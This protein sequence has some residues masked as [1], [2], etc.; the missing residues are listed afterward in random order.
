MNK[1]YS[2]IVWENY[3]SMDTP[4]NEANLNR[5]DDALNTIDDRVVEMS[6]T[7]LDKNTAYTMVK[8]ISFNEDTGIFTITYL[9]G[10]TTTLDTKL[11]KL[12][13][14]FGFNPEIEKLT[15]TL[16]DGTVQEVDLSA[17]ISKYEFADSD[18][19]AFTVDSSGKVTA[20][21]KEGSIQGKHLQPNYLADVTQQAEAAA[22]SA[23]SAENSASAASASAVAAAEAAK[24]AE[25]ASGVSIAST[26]K[27]GIVKP[28][29]ETITVGA[30]GTIAVSETVTKEISDVRNDLTN[31]THTASEVGAV[32]TSEFAKTFSSYTSNITGKGWYRVAKIPSNYGSNSCEFVITTDYANNYPM[33]CKLKY[34][35]AHTTHKIYALDVLMYNNSNVI[36]NARITTDGT[37]SYL[38][39]Y[40]ISSARNTVKIDVMD[41]DNITGKL[42]SA[43]EPVAT[44]ETVDGVTVH[45]YY[46]IPTNLKLAS[47]YEFIGSATGTTQIS[48]D[49]SQY[50]ELVYNVYVDGVGTFS[51]TFII[52]G[53]HING[54]ENMHVYVQYNPEENF[55]KVVEAKFNGTDVTSRATLHVY[56]RRK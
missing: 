55:A 23:E 50:S 44:S 53:W 12:A 40:Y 35:N 17:L 42:W 36:K 4:V 45:C 26:Q 14:N 27:A 43:I 15:I 11:E 8:N 20:I 29:G 54:Y 31:H 48:I 33:Q 52:S 7:K 46:V 24:R 39:I 41:C 30:D 19:I 21:V 16:E 25:A 34:V 1:A 10:S 13:V 18:S 49:T 51:G 56:G 37:N 6:S 38:E 5:M 32:S 9:N 3:P 22:E 47:E 28:D 2:R